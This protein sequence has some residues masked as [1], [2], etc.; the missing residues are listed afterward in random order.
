M[1]V[2]LV[3]IGVEATYFEKTTTSHWIQAAAVQRY[4]C[5]C[6][7]DPERIVRDMCRESSSQEF[8]LKY[9]EI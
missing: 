6:G 3:F 5:M 9:F 1:L 4:V 7:L 8:R 2:K